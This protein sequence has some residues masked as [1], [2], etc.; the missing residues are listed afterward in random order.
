MFY[1]VSKF[2][3]LFYFLLRGLSFFRWTMHGKIFRVLIFPVRKVMKIKGFF[4]NC[5]LVFYFIWLWLVFFSNFIIF[6][7]FIEP[8]QKL[9]TPIIK[10]FPRSATVA[11]GGSV[12]FSTE[13]EGTS[14]KGKTWNCFCHFSD[15]VACLILSGI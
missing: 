11:K 9:K 12:D 1:L 14:L 2:L 3:L 7:N 10:T 8:N 15:F 5:L 6:H 13:F 4:R